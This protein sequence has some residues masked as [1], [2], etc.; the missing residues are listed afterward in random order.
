[1]I[2]EKT[3]GS[4]FLSFIGFIMWFS[5]TIGILLCMEGLSAF[6]HGLRL[7]WVEFNGKF[8]Q[9][10]GYMFEPFTL[11]TIKYNPLNGE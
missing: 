3:R 4:G 8:Y 7:H 1:M 2:I 6:L 9:G 11:K 10:N 5:L